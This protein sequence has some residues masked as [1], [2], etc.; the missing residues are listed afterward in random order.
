M[1]FCQGLQAEMIV[2]RLIYALLCLIIG[3]L[4]AMTAPGAILLLGWLMTLMRK[5]AI[6]ATGGQ[7]GIWDQ[8]RWWFGPAGKTAIRRAFGGIAQNLRQ[9]VFATASLAVATFPFAVFWLVAWWAGW[10]NSFNKG[11]EQAFV[12]PSVGLA[13]VA[14]FAVI[15]IYLP[16]ALV[17]QAV[18]D[19]AWSLFEL[20][21][22][23]AITAATGWGYVIWAL[24]NL[25]FSLPILAGRGL[26]VF[27]EQIAPGL[28]DMTPTQIAD[29]KTA[30]QLGTAAY[31]FVS[32]II[33][34][35]WS[36]RIYAHGVARASQSRHADILEGIALAPTS[37]DRKLKSK[38]RIART[39]RFVALFVIWS[40]FAFVI[41][42]GQFLNH[43]W[44]VWL[45]HPY[46]FLP[47]TR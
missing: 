13:G 9:G 11:Y 28:A 26:P 12:G 37:R 16:M 20:R 1:T 22:V 34:K 46:V 24:A 41:F 36:A 14:V 21:R 30:I 39:L 42:V 45:S 4:L 3:S 25:V 44:L 35:R 43:D 2:L 32:L 19:R 47:W 6:S 38:W 10:E 17:H 18:E 31:I 23:R 40:A 15:M 29:L 33:L 8:P 5:R 27:G 7:P